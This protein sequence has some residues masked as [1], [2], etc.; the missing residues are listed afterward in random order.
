[1][2]MSYDDV[3]AELA[4]ALTPEGGEPLD[5][6]LLRLTQHNCYSHAPKPQPVRYRGFVDLKVCARTRVCVCVGGGGSGGGRGQGEGA[7]VGREVGK[8]GR[9]G[10]R[11]LDPKP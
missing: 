11:V 7:E 9:G 1:M 6:L 2:E 8:G 3:T 5:P 10:F 4:T